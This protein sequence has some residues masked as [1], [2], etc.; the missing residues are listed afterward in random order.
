[1]T[2]KTTV[3]IRIPDILVSGIQMVTDHMIRKTPL[4]YQRQGSGI[5]LICALSD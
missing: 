5:W 2:D 3:G 4:E 1:M